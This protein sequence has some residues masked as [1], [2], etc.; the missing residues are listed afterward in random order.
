M[1][2][3]YNTVEAD[4]SVFGPVDEHFTPETNQFVLEMVIE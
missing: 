2:S 3:A 1:N 4:G